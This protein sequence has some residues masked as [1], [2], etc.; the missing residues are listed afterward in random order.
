MSYDKTP[1]GANLRLKFGYCPVEKPALKDRGQVPVLPPIWTFPG[2]DKDG[3]LTKKD[4]GHPDWVTG[5]LAKPCRLR[6]RLLNQASDP[7]QD[8]RSDERDD[9]GSDPSATRP[10]TDDPEKPSADYSTE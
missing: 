7:D 6:L 1:E 10:N 2:L 9:D 5:A 4:L 3:G 8:Y